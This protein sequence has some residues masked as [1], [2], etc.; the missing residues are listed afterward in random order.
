M[1]IRPA[2]FAI[3]VVSVVIFAPPSFAQV[4]TGTPPFGSFASSPDTV[5]LA[6]GNVELTIPVLNKA[7]RGLPFNYSLS[8][9][10]NNALRE[11][12]VGA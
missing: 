9:N 2:P 11:A 12:S 5:S 6:N 3:L 4:S 1:R 10:L 7:G 8:Y